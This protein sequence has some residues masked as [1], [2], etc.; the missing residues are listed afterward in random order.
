MEAQL[1]IKPSNGMRRKPKAKLMWRHGHAAN[2]LHLVLSV[3]G[4]AR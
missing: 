1:I 4:W 2:S 3:R